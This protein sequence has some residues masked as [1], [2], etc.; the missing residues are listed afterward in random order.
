MPA[1]LVCGLPSERPLAL[2]REA[3][4]EVGAEV[5][6]LD[7]RR[8]DDTEL[9]FGVSD[10]AVGGW[11]RI[12]DRSFRLE[13]FAGVYT[14]IVDEQLSPELR[15]EPAGSSR[16]RRGRALTETFARWCEVSPARV[17]NR[18]R[19]MGSNNSKPYQAQVA[20]RHGFRIPE[21]LITNDPDRARAFRERHGR[22]VYKSISGVRSIVS[23]LEE[24][25]LARL[26]RIRLCPVQFQEFVEGTNVRVHVVDDAVFATSIE[27]EATDY[28]Y[29]GRVDTEEVELAPAE[30]QPELAERCVGL[31][32]ALDLPFA[33]IDLKL[34]PDG[35]ACCFEVNPSPA[36]SYYESQTGQ[37]IARAVA[38]YLAGES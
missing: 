38:R 22:V 34:A 9:A 37:P 31:A 27:T 10:G 6:L 18:S 33:G 5:V 16:R 24:R 12:G 17:V 23:T 4:D 26:G 13:D 28:R 2:V 19:A 30:L 32:R 25:D 14:R 20:R 7:Q 3:L 8:F 35:G 15:D 11:L 21:T 1:V 29:A 36:F